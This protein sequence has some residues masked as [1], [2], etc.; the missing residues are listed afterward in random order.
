[1]FDG[2]LF[3]KHVKT[4]WKGMASILSQFAL[5]DASCG[6]GTLAFARFAANARAVSEQFLPRGPTGAGAVGRASTRVW[7]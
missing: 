2:V 5:P 7:V 6:L 3:T 4:T 1:M